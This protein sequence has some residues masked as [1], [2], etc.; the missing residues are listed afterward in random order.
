[1]ICPN[2]SAKRESS[3]GGCWQCGVHSEHY[4]RAKDRCSH[5]IKWDAECLACERV[6]SEA[7]LKEAEARVAYHRQRLANIE[8]HG[9]RTTRRVKCD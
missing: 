9:E 6:W 7:M 5:G 1:M 3:V 8:K 4:V 2:C